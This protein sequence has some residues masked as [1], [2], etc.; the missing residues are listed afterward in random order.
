MRKI[1]TT[2]K[3]TIVYEGLQYNGKQNSVALLVADLEIWWSPCL[4]IKKCHHFENNQDIRKLPR[5]I[6]IKLFKV[7]F[8]QFNLKKNCNGILHPPLSWFELYAL[9]YTLYVTVCLTCSLFD[10]PNTVK[11]QRSKVILD[12][13]SKLCWKGN[14]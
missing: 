1:D 5:Q 7:S 13:S 4:K 12:H 3:K 14:P 11:T 6:Y 8:K 9:R 2:F 10:S